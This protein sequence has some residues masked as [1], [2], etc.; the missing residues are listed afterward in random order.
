MLR[1]EADYVLGIAA[2]WQGEF[3]AARRRFEAAVDRYRP[4]HR[5]A[6]LLRYGL[7]PKVVCLSRLGNTLWFLGQPAA[8]ARARDAALALADEVGHPFSR[9]T[10]LVFATLLSLDMRD[11][12]GVRAYAARLRAEQEEHA[13]KPS[14]LAAEHFG[15]YVDVLDDR[16]ATGIARI[17]RALDDSRQ[18]DDAPGMRAHS[19]RV[20]LEAC[21]ATR[22]ARAGL[23]AADWALGL[24][25]AD[26]LWEAETRRLR[27]EF[28]AALGAPAR[29][30][31]AELERALAVARRQG[32]RMLELRAA[33]SL[34]RRR[35][36]RGDPT[37]HQ[38]REQLTAIVAALPE[39]RDCQD[40]REAAILLGGS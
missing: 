34:L 24:G 12:D 14:L 31:D 30:V 21:A 7:D 36:E 26:R 29:D 22:D 39:A 28:L 23:A 9:A 11:P 32:A 18:A 19:L 27:A 15:G 20:L 25:D 13:L 16:A 10:A 2:F 4:E 6:H 33:T 38:S 1:V 35:L 37:A 5:R 17:Q 40:M 3:D 8:A